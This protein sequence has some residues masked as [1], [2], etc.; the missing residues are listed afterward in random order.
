MDI[1]S[2]APGLH[3]QLFANR[4]LQ[5]RSILTAES[6]PTLD[7]YDNSL[8]LARP[9]LRVNISRL[10]EVSSQQARPSDKSYVNLNARDF[11]SLIDD[12]SSSFNMQLSVLAERLR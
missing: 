2:L 3:I 7:S 8:P 5:Q 9:S 6:S 1:V 4:H 10:G 12:I 11:S